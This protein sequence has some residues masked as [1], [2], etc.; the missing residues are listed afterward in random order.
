MATTA[1]A[2]AVPAATAAAAT[3]AV[4]VRPMKV[5]SS[6]FDRMFSV[7]GFYVDLPP[8]R[9][10]HIDAQSGPDDVYVTKSDGQRFP[11]PRATLALSFFTVQ[12]KRALEVLEM[13]EHAP[14]AQRLSANS[15]SFWAS[16][17]ADMEENPLFAGIATDHEDTIAYIL[18]NRDRVFAAL[19]AVLA[20]DVG[21]KNAALEKTRRK[22]F[23]ELD[24]SERARSITPLLPPL[25][26]TSVAAAAK[27]AGAKDVAEFFRDI[28]MKTTANQDMA[29]TLWKS[30]RGEFTEEELATAYPLWRKDCAKDLFW[31]GGP[32]EDGSMSWSDLEAL[33]RAG[34]PLYRKKAGGAPRATFGTK[35]TSD[36]NE[37]APA[38]G[39]PAAAAAAAAAAAVPLDDEFEFNPI[40]IYDETN[41]SE[42]TMA[43]EEGERTTSQP[44]LI[45]WLHP[46]NRDGSPGKVEF[47]IKRGM[48]VRLRIGWR[49]Q[50]QPGQRW[51]LVSDV[52]RRTGISIC[53]KREELPDEPLP[54][55]RGPRAQIEDCVA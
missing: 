32:R 50:H 1:A 38:A 3:T 11:K 18:E 40:A 49:L 44:A 14:E 20:N 22:T 35:R 54:M 41:P 34:F 51:D 7:T 6:A 55:Y 47:P 30:S 46:V 29:F 31:A 43:T 37:K 9:V 25:V 24:P 39:D 26:R 27:K 5:T 28:W 17:D 48:Y 10:E 16:S 23:D 4:S 8:M 2:A 19:Y 42:I 21:Q 36:G 53:S 52:V 33:I 45:D 13:G 15:A 12:Q